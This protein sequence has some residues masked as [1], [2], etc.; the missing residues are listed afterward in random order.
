MA[1]LNKVTIIGYVGKDPDMKYLA[2][3]DPVTEFS[4]GV[5]GWGENAETEWF[6][7]VAFKQTAETVGSYVTKGKQIY[8]EG[9]QKTDRWEDKETGQQR[10]RVK[11]IVSNVVLLG[12]KD[13]F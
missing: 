1:G 13:E 2:S 12:K 10:S 7:C 5:T 6:S 11:L 3:G 8:V 9:R 4:V